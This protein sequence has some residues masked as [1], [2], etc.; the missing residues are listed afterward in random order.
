MPRLF[1]GGQ[2]QPVDDRLRGPVSRQGTPGLTEASYKN[3][4]AFN[5]LKTCMKCIAVLRGN[6]VRDA[7]RP[8]LLAAWRCE[9]TT[10]SVA[11]G[12]PTRE[13]GNE[14][15]CVSHAGMEN[16]GQRNVSELC[17]VIETAN[18]VA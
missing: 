10:R 7:L 14:G 15:V 8:I 17:N 5:M 13:R 2:R 12:I 6:A 9:R 3:V 1:P 18:G 16:R 11:D 4:L